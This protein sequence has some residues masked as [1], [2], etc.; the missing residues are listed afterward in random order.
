MIKL[1]F[2]FSSVDMT[3]ASLLAN[4]F[5]KMGDMHNRELLVT[6]CWKDHFGIEQLVKD[7]SPHFKHVDSYVMEDVPEDLGWPQAANHMF[8]NSCIWLAKHGNTEPFYFFEA[9]NFPLYPC[10][11]DAFEIEY[12]EAVAA[13]KPYMGFINKTY[14]TINGKSGEERGVHMVGTGIYPANF[15]D[16]CESIHTLTDIPW[17]IACQ[18]EIISQCHPTAKIFHAWQ[19]GNYTLTTAG[20]VGI[21][22]SKFRGRYGGRVVPKGTCN[23]HGAKDF[24]LYQI[25]QKFFNT[26]Q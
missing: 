3:L 9:D 7:L 13:G 18:E 19:T 23:I 12:K 8:Y 1:I 11:L 15:L 17:D 10:W 14:M 21:D 25:P 2:P 4:R 26:L 6:C 16:I 20:L 24:S 22:L 5:T